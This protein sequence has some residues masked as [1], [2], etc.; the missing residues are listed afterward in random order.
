MAYK[1]GLCVP[2]EKLSAVAVAPDTALYLQMARVRL[3]LGRHSK[4]KGLR[5]IFIHG[6]GD[7]TLRQAILDYVKESHPAFACFDAPFD[8]YGHLGATAVEI[9]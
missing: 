6:K 1:L 2:L 4:N 3:E 5:I 8:K 9:R 7:G